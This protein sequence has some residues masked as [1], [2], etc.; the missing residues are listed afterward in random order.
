MAILK[1]ILF[2]LMLIIIWAAIF[3]LSLRF[4]YV[5]QPKFETWRL[6]SQ[7]YYLRFE[8]D[9]IQYNPQC[10]DYDATLGYVTKPGECIFKSREYQTRFLTN[11]LGL[12]DDEDS[13]IQP[14]VAVIGDS[15]AAGWG[16]DNYQVFPFLIETGTNLKTINVSVSSY[17]TAR[18][19]MLL[20]KVDTSQLRHLII[21][22][23]GND[24]EENIAFVNN[25]G[26]L[27]V[28]TKEK[29]DSLTL[30][31]YS[32]TDVPPVF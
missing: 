8:R 19:L 27:P 29:Y 4:L 13:L 21:Q 12:R 11:S 32:Q 25:R 30:Q 9:I 31:H 20:N 23:C 5:V 2:N 16:V 28:M 14:A 18:E 17:G 10:A 7:Q 26:T 15:Y 6:A 3:E 22:F 24:Q 1:K